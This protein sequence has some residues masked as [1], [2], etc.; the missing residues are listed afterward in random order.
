MSVFE[1]WAGGIANRDADALID[2]LHDDYEF[3]RHQTG[4]SMNKAAMSDML[5]GF[6]ANDAVVVHSQRCLYENDGYG[7]AISHG[8]CR[9][10]SGSGP[11]FQYPQRRQDHSNGNRS[12]S[13]RQELS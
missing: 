11:G 12:D 7:R 5:R 13:R 4:T 2:C 3:V 1:K 9:W 8:F 10:Q 6:M